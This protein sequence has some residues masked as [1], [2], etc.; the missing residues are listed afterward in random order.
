MGDIPFLVSKNSADVWAYKN[1]FKLDLSSG[2]PP[3]MYFSNG[4]R[5]GMPPYNWTNIAAD[6]YAYIRHRLN[7][8]Q[9]FYNM[10]RIDHFVGLFRI[11]TIENKT[12]EEYG[13]M[14]GHF[15]P[16]N[17]NE[18]E[19]HGRTILSEMNQSTDMLPCAEDLGTVPVCSDKILKEFGVTGI[20]VQRW[21]KNLMQIIRDI[22]LLQ[23]YHNFILRK[24][25][26]AV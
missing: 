10:F 11:W 9:N 8:A 21:E 23:V 5:W 15:D 26:E 17:E 20:S 18:W 16:E 24:H 25:S 22:F 7:Y 19:H 12:P 13:G 6:N 1:Y 3:D 14:A 2:A 4:Q